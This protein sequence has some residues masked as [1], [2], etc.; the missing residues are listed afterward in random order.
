MMDDGRGGTERLEMSRE[1]GC[2][3]RRVVVCSGVLV[4]AWTIASGT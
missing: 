1:V 2:D 3:G 4:D